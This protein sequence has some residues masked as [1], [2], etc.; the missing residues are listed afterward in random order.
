MAG[1]ASAALARNYFKPKMI[2]GS[3][4]GVLDTD[5]KPFIPKAG[6]DGNVR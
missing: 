2:I 5:F 6:G 1:T 4:P 3:L